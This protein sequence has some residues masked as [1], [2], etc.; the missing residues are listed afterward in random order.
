MPLVNRVLIWLAAATTLAVLLWFLAALLFGRQAILEFLFGAP[1]RMTVSFESLVPPGTPNSYLVCPAGFCRAARPAAES[2]EYD[3]PAARL[4]TAWMRMLERQP[5][6]TVLAQ[7][8]AERQLDIEQRSLLVGYP[9]TVTVRFIP[10][11]GSRSTLAV[12][13]RSHYGR[14]DY[15]VN[16]ER[17]EHW[18][19]DLA[20]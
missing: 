14:S 19:D 5:R 1:D 17:V 12:Y 4:E 9:D 3:V 11:Q 15:G 18:L 16:K 13:S 20:L 7:D 10:L 6:V 2:P 8:A